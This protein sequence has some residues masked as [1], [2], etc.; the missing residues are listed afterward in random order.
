MFDTKDLAAATAG[1]IK[2]YLQQNFTSRLD[3]FEKR[4]AAIETQ[5]QAR[6]RSKKVVAQ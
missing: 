5:A 4:L 6:T 1:V 3:D 2:E